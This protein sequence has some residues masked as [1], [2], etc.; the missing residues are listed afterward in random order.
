LPLYLL[1]TN[2]R[3]ASKLRDII[4]YDNTGVVFTCSSEIIIILEATLLLDQR[5]YVREALFATNIQ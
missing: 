2:D 3:A 1:L 5:K 4:K